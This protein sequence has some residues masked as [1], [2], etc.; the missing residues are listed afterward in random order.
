MLMEKLW[1]ARCAQADTGVVPAWHKGILA[2]RLR[3]LDSSSESASPWRDV[4]ERIR[5][6]TKGG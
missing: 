2:E 4:R 1:V 6:Q 5:A 3:R